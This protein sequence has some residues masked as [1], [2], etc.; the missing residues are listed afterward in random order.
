MRRTTE[1]AAT[2]APPPMDRS[3]SLASFPVVIHLIFASKGPLPVDTLLSFD[4]DELLD[5]SDSV[6][7][8]TSSK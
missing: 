6:H 1:A 8:S 3:T 4:I 5:D 2:P 7:S